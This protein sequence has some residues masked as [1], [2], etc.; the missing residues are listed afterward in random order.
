LILIP[1]KNPSLI[2]GFFVGNFLGRSRLGQGGTDFKAAG[3]L[4]NYPLA[5]TFGLAPTLDLLYARSPNNSITK[6]LIDLYN[7]RV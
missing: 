7:P 5:K 3:L 1:T 2:D 6:K 4:S